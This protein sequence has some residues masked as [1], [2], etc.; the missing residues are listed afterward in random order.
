MSSFGAAVT[1]I[2]VI[3]GIISILLTVLGLY[4]ERRARNAKLAEATELIESIGNDPQTNAQDNRKLRL[5]QVIGS[6]TIHDYVSSSEVSNQV[7]RY[8]SQ[9]FWERKRRARA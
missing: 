7:D 8:L 6:F 4:R 1:V 3:A 5:D 2:G 9:A